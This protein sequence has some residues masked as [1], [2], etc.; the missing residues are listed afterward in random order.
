MKK[1]NGYISPAKDEGNMYSREILEPHQVFHM[2]YITGRASNTSQF[3]VDS[4]AHGV[5]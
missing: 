5:K 3:G 4:T 1:K 2:T